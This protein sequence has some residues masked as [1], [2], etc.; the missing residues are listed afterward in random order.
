M[1][2]ETVQDGVADPEEDA[3]QKCSAERRNA[4]ILRKEPG[5][6]LNAER[7]EKQVGEDAQTQSADGEDHQTQVDEVNDEA[8]EDA[9]D[10]T[11]WPE[12]AMEGDAVD[13]GKEKDEEERVHEDAHDEALHVNAFLVFG[14]YVLELVSVQKF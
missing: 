10:H 2:K 12:R 4:E 7:R 6:R 11:F 9:G 14:W 13:D 1:S 3:R 8:E 5:H